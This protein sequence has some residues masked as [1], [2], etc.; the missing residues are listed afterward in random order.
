MSIISLSLVQWW[1]ATLQNRFS[2]SPLDQVHSP[3]R[4]ESEPPALSGTGKGHHPQPQHDINAPTKGRPPDRDA[5]VLDEHVMHKIKETVCHNPSSHEQGKE[6]SSHYR[7]G[8]KPDGVYQ[9]PDQ[10]VTGTAQNREEHIIGRD[11][12]ENGGIEA[13]FFIEACELGQCSDRN[14]KENANNKGH[15]V[16]PV[17]VQ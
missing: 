12:D 6:E 14:T 1:L 9:F 11:D 16:S 4:T 2:G 8:C 10:G 15:Q 5:G 7:D 13:A 17:D 3:S